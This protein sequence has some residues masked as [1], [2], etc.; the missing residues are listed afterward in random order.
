MKGFTEDEIRR[1]LVGFCGANRNSLLHY[2][3]FSA[4]L[5]NEAAI[6]SG[7]VPETFTTEYLA[8]FQS[9]IERWLDK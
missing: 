5:E 6:N 3:A 8:E 4:M 1:A 2:L 9:A 7:G